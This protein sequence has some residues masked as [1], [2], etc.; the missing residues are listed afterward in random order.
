MTEQTVEVD[1]VEKGQ[2][3]THREPTALN[4]GQVA[5]YLRTH[6]DFFVGRDDL[7]LDLTLP[8][9]RGDAI[10]LVERQ[11]ALLR[12]RALDYRHQLARLADNAR[13]NEKLFERMR[14]L[15]LSLLESKDLEQLVEVIGDSLNHEFGIEFHSL[16]LFREKPMNLPVRVEHTDVVVEALGS[17]MTSGKAICGQ[18]TQAELD[19]LF[20]EQAGNVG[21]VAIAP[22]SYAFSEPQQLGVL[23]L[24][25]QDKHHFK[26]SMGTLFISYLG[27]ILSRVLAR[28]L[29][30]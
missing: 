24:G 8:H 11:V 14:L 28:Q 4:P 26:A 3:E 20:Q 25:S 19:F 2:Q 23:A 6:P 17:I 21:S 22:L 18:V 7:L 9:Q 12:E 10:S 15:V 1:E 27:D 5:D 16:I 13:E 29:H 30:S